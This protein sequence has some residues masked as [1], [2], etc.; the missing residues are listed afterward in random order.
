[1]KVD[2]FIKRDFKV[3]SPLVGVAEIKHQ[4]LIESAIVIMEEN[5]YFGILTTIDL[6]RKPHILV[7]DC[8][9]YKIEIGKDCTIS[10]ALFNMKKYNSD[11]LPVFEDGHISGLVFKNDILD[12]LNQH[13]IELQTELLNR[14]KT[15]ED[16]NAELIKIIKDQKEDLA[17]VVEQRT[18][19]LIDLVETKE[20][21]IRIIVHEL[22]NPFT[23]ILGF[24]NLMQDNVRVYDISKIEKFLTI[25]YRTASITFDLLVSLSEWLN[26]KSNNIPF[27]PEKTSIF[28][29]LNEEIETTQ[30]TA[31]QKKILI[32]NQVGED[33][34]VFADKN[35]VRTIFRN[36]INN[37]IKFTENN[38]VIIIFADVKDDYIEISVKDNGVGMTKE[39]LTSI[40]S[41][42]TIQSLPGTNNEKGTG[43]GL[44]LCKEFVEIEGGKIWVE[45]EVGHGSLFKFT[46]PR[47]I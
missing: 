31:S 40:F 12:Y 14:T 15:L 32:H 47:F 20:K 23:S 45:S 41:E 44:L 42:S 13:Q 28:E 39:I 24:L 43:L 4:L 16:K 8:I 9:S 3:A 10:D 2:Y 34:Y 30:L 18:R 36:M 11:V 22:R 46:L 25:V 7:L 26:A 1:M 27:S 19:E 33:V 17:A 21:I 35:M 5:Q 37:G 6:L 38:G 29:M